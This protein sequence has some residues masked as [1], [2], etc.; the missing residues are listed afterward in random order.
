MEFPK[1]HIDFYAKKP[2]NGTPGH[3]TAFPPGR[4]GFAK[5]RSK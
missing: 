2:E 4:R 1:S 3:E 5:E